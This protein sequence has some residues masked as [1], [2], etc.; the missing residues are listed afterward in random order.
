MTERKKFVAPVLSEEAGLAALTL[1]A[2]ASG[3][4][5]ETGT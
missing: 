3:G 5:V 1:Q 2:Q 4:R